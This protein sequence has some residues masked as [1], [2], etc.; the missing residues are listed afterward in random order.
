MLGIQMKYIPAK[1]KHK[2]STGG[3][4]LSNAPMAI[5]KPAPSVNNKFWSA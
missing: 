3:R 2:Y 4:V 5:L 1:I